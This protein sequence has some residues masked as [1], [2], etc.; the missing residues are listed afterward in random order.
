MYVLVQP[1][2]WAWIKCF[3]ELLGQ[4]CSSWHTVRDRRLGQTPVVYHLISSQHN[5]IEPI[6]RSEQSCCHC[7]IPN[8]CNISFTF[9]NVFAY[10]NQAKTYLGLNSAAWHRPFSTWHE[11]IAHSSALQGKKSITQMCWHLLNG[12]ELVFMEVLYQTG[13]WPPNNR[14][15]YNSCFV[16]VILVTLVSPAH[17]INKW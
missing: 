7:H 12:A 14:W 6:G 4:S 17:I 2:C 13:I 16:T 1:L 9:H 10:F 5:Q 11:Y 8:W 3:L 15:Y